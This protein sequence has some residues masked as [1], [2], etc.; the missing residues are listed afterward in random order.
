M[1]G[2]AFGP[3]FSLPSSCSLALELPS[4]CKTALLALDPHLT[5]ILTL[6]F[7]G[8]RSERFYRRSC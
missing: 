5:G 7:L 1:Y 8:D 4:S 3:W 2:A 6:S